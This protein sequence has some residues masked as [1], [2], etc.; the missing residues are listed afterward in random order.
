[1]DLLQW[2]KCL[3]AAR[4]LL[5]VQLGATLGRPSLYAA[6]LQ[7]PCIGVAHSWQTVLYP[8]SVVHYDAS[9]LS[10]LPAK[11]ESAESDATGCR[12]RLLH[13]MARMPDRAT[14]LL[15]W[16]EGLAKT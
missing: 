2:I 5:H 16:L 13:E 4:G 14:R 9:L 6:Y 8:D 3:S 11:I 7:K 1:M 15:T 12:G 10:D